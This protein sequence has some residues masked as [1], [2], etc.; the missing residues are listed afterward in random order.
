MVLILYFWVSWWNLGNYCLVN[1]NVWCK[2]LKF[3]FNKLFNFGFCIFIIIVFFV[4]NI[5]WCIW[6]KLVD[7]RGVILNCWK[8]LSI[9]LCN[10]CLIMA[11]VW[12]ELKGGI[13]F[14]SWV[15]VLIYFVGMIFV[16]VERD[17]LILIKVG[18]K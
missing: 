14:W 9:V 16:L 4:G 2:S 12:W 13:W 18:F 8:I 1:C 11:I 10:F 3:R 7:V 6:F 5:V 17:W 15:K